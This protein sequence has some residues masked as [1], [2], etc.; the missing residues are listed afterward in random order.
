M[1]NKRNRTSFFKRLHLTKYKLFVARQIYR[2]IR[3]FLHKEKY[4]IRRSKINYEIDIS[5][6]IDLSIFLFGCFQ[7]H[8]INNKYISIPRD[9][10]IFD[11]GANIG[12]MTLK[13]AQKA[14]NG[15]VYA[16][17]PTDYAY[18]KLI[19]NIS[20]NPGLKERITPVQ[21]FFGKKTTTIHGMKAYSSW[22]IN[23]KV[24]Q[25]HPFHGGSIRSAVNIS[26]I[27]IDDFC[28]ENDIKRLNL[29]KIDTDGYEYQVLQGAQKTLLEL[30]PTIIFEIG[31]SQF[32][33]Y[34]VKVK[35]EQFLDFFLSKGYRLINSKNGNVITKDNYLRHIPLNSTF[36][37]I[38]LRSL[39]INT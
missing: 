16:F 11:I 31:L 36:D 38:A 21:K 32:N 14:P 8:V 35:F 17:E 10:V 34:N 26:A 23:K 39:R 5:E 1:R 22:K 12:A 28:R 33:E 30:S 24:N 3:I 27:S 4:N 6:G 13:F 15:R 29:I 25:A 9:A 19:K 18:K 37:V 20:L 2:L 7:K